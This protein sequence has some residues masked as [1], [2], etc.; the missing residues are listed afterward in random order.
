MLSEPRQTAGPLGSPDITPA[1]RYF[2]PGRLPLAVH[3]LPGVSGY[4]ASLLR[5]F[6]G[7]DEEGFSSCLAR[8]CRRAVPNTPPKRLAASVSCDDPCCLRPKT[9]GSTFGFEFS[10]PP[11]GLLA[12]RPSDLLTILKMALSIGFRSSVSFLSAIQ[13]TGLLTFAPVGLSPTEHASLSWTR[14]FLFLPNRL[15]RLPSP[16]QFSRRSPGHAAFTAL[17]VLHSRPSTGNASLATSLSLIGLLTPVPP[18]DPAS[19][20]EVTHRSSVPC[21]PQT[22][23]CGG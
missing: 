9:G 14:G 1:H 16:A 8:P 10:R 15:R 7:R 18:G 2:G 19:P 20:P 12:L 21:H 23:W 11:M 4:T 3:R 17:V 22:P 6:L 5:R 13:A